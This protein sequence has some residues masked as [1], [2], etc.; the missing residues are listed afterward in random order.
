MYLQPGQAI[1]NRD[2]ESCGAQRDSKKRHQN[3][4]QKRCREGWLTYEAW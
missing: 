4:R 1:T 3:V 2:P